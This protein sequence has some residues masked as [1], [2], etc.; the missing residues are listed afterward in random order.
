M[1][2]RILRNNFQK[3]I[4]FIIGVSAETVP[5]IN[6]QLHIIKNKDCYLKLGSWK[7]PCNSKCIIMREEFIFSFVLIKQGDGYDD[8]NCIHIIF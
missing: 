7:S 6:S 4:F 3:L 8:I 2:S 5:R 1:S